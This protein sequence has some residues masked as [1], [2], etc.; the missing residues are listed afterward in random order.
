VLF[1]EQGATDAAIAAYDAVLRADPHHVSAYK[2][3]GELLLGAGRF[4]AWLAN[5]AR[6][7]ASCPTALPLAVQ[8]LEACVYL[9]DFAKLDRYLE[10]LR[11]ERFRPADELELVDAL[12]QLLY[13]LQFHDVEPAM[14]FG[15]ARAYDA[16]ARSVYGD[17]LP[18]A[19]VRR[20]GRLRVG[21]LSADLRNHVQGKMVWQAVERHDRTRFELYL[22]S[23]ATQEDAWTERFRAVAD[24]FAVIAPLDER[25]A[26]RRIAAD[27]L[28]LLVDLGTHTKGARPGILALKPARVQITHVASAGTVGLS[29]VDYKLTDRFADLP[30]NQPFQLEKLLPM[31]GCVYPYRHV[32]AAPEHPFQREGLGIAPGTIVIGAFVSGLK[33]SRRCLALWRDVL[34]RLP[35]ARL[36]FS[37][38]NPALR[39]LYARIA[40]AGG[41]PAGRLI[42]VPQ[43]RDDEE[44]QA[45]YDVVDFVLDPMPY[46]GVNGTLEALDMGVPVVTLVGGRH[47]ERT[48]YSI[49]ANLGV[50]Q[51]LAHSGREYVDIA[52]RLARDPQFMREVRA[53]IRAGLACSPLTD[54]AGHTR[55]LERAY[56]AALAQ[57]APAALAAAGQG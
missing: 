26:A 28:D 43:G 6:F 36:A 55:N 11:H 44:N 15:F 23:L 52:V 39:T 8:A 22:Y 13:L 54:M 25:A 12:E 33:L 47:G 37:P 21:Y 17:P 1:Q 10:G 14:I 51:T 7:E 53:A 38:L 24:S 29:A 32:P 20:P 2:N 27:D 48:S 9:P 19:T 35:T 16:A 46:G 42:F 45:R 30:E 57:S 31:D 34:A 50:T 5:F 41:I 40:A 49:L 4:D 18:R 3:R 56:L